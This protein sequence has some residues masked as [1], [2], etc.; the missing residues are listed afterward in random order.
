LGTQTRSRYPTRKISDVVRALC[1]L[2]FV[3]IILSTLA[4][5]FTHKKDRGFIASSAV[6]PI[7]LDLAQ[8]FPFGVPTV[9]FEMRLLNPR[10]GDFTGRIKGNVVT[11]QCVEKFG[12]HF[13]RAPIW[14]EDVRDCGNW[15]NSVGFLMSSMVLEIDAPNFSMGQVVHIGSE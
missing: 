6:P 11:A 14:P 1:P 5:T 15:Q 4:I 10:I 8:V 9:L 12:V 7:D 2:R 13:Q 3:F